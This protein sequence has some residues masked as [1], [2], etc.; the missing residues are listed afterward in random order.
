MLI[1]EDHSVSRLGLATL[2]RM[3]GWQ[4]SSATTIHE[5]MGLLNPAPDCVLLDLCLPDGNGEELLQKL[6]RESPVSRVIVTTGCR[7]DSRLAAIE[8]FGAEAIF[9]KPIDLSR[10]F[11]MCT[12]QD[13]ERSARSVPGR[14]A[15]A[16]LTSN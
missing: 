13:I 16:A 5:A 3:R 14:P 12:F 8:R 6:Q 15:E 1:V 4:V 11:N 2:F 7:D 10:L 9:S